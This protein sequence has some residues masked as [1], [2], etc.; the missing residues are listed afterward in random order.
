MNFQDVAYEGFQDGVKRYGFRG[1]LT[2]KQI[3]AVGLGRQML[4]ASDLQKDS[5]LAMYLNSDLVAIHDRGGQ[6][7]QQNNQLMK[8]EVTDFSGV[9]RTLEVL[10]VGAL[11]CKFPSA[12]AREDAFWGL[13]CPL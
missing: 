4:K 8:K 11:Y 10:M 12:A 6:F 5:R 13:I 2:M 9:F 3:E 1:R 7:K